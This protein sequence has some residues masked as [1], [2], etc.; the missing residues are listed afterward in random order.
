MEYSDEALVREIKTG[1]SSAMDILVRRWYPRIY[2]YIFKMLGHEQD[3]HD[4]T[5]DTFLAMIQNVR[6]YHI[7]NKFQSWIFTIAHNKC[8][9]FFR[10]QGR[11]LL[12]DIESIENHAANDVDE[13]LTNLG[14][15][16]NA[17]EQLSIVQR[18]V[19]ILHYFQ[20]FT[21]REISQMTDTPVPTLKS[22]L[23]S[24]K[25]SLA[26]LLREDFA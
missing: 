16:E 13:L 10:L 19:I 4:V 22:R 26:E 6:L 23:T 7:W 25:R 2:G 11:V 24:A 18:E 9:D 3:A 15:I 14:I 20:G 17:L 1:D 21:V 12:V 5:Q 8:M